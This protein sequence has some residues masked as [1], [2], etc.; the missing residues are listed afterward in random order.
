MQMKLLSFQSKP[1]NK[2]ICNSSE[3]L[4]MFK[5]YRHVEIAE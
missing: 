4:R 2:L 5:V 3:K 1:T